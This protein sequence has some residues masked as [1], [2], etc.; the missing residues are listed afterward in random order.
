M[1]RIAVL[2]DI[3]GNLPAFEAALEHV[4]RQSVDQ[5]ILAGDIINGA[6]D[7]RE[8]WA[9]ARSLGCPI[10]RGNHERYAAHFGTPQAP[11]LW[12]QEQFAPVQWTVAQLSAQERQEMERLPLNRRLPAAPGVFFVHAS[13][14]GDHDT[15]A[16]HTPE[17]Q[18]EEMF[19]AAQ[20]GLIVRAHNHYG[21]VRVWPKGLIVTCGSVGLNLDGNLAAQYLLIE[22]ENHGWKFQH[23]SV[24]YPVETA[25]ERFHTTGYLSAVGPMG[26]L[27]YRELATAAQHIVP[28]LRY[29]AQWAAEGQITLSQAVERFLGL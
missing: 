29:Y 23:Q 16:A 19:P 6:P 18:L 8:C 4:A 12:T 17:A 24:P 10:L 22:R 11:P 27:F 5:I 7:S 15:I 20:E 13:E 25:L 1:T 9:L 3:H 14:R 26:R 28:F 2:A 21:Q